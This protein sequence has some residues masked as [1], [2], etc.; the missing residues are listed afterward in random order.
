MRAV[1]IACCISLPPRPPLR[2]SGSTASGPSK[3]AARP[4]PADTF[5]SRTVPTIRPIGTVEQKLARVVVGKSF[6][7]DFFLANGD[8][9]HLLPCPVLH[10]TAS[11]RMIEGK[12]SRLIAGSRRYQ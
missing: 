6:L 10:G 7:S 5:Q 3:S 4:G 12:G 9:G 2:Y 1:A 8:H 11:V